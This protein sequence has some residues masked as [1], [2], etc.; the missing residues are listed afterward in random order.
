MTDENVLWEDLRKLNAL[1]E[2]LRWNH[3]DPLTFQIEGDK[4]VIRNIFQ[5]QR[6]K[7]NEHFRRGSR[8]PESSQEVT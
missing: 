7:L 1:Y 2:E 8:P 3:T 4:I 6:D 5:E